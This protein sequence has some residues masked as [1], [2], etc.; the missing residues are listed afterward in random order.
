MEKDVQTVRQGLQKRKNGLLRTD[1]NRYQSDLS[2]FLKFLDKE[3]I[4]HN[5]LESQQLTGYE[6]DFE[7]WKSHVRQKGPDFPH[8]ERERAA[9]CL[10]I[11]EHY[12]DVGNSWSLMLDMGTGESN[13]RV[14]TQQ[15]MEYF[16][17]P[18]YEYLDEQLQMRQGMITSED[19]MKET[20][21]LVDG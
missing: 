5:V 6:L 9:M 18:L 10:T 7:T 13:I 19:V 3:P 1:N 4:L 16:A 14:L 11:L 8:D 21:A 15:F 2:M 20:Q 17:V 12:V